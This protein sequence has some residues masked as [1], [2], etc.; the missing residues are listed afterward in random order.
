MSFE[1]LVLGLFSG[2]RPGTSL[3]AVLVLLRAPA[4]RRPLLFFTAAG[5]A[6]SWVVGVVVVG[7]FHGADV[8]IGGGTLTAVLDVAFG[9]A[10]LG[11][12]AGL[13]RGWVQPPARRTDVTPRFA[14]LRDPS[15]RVA[16]A[17]GVATHFPGLIY[18]VALNAIAAEQPGVLGTGLQVALYDVLWFM[19]PIG[20]LVLVIVRPGVALAWLEAATAWARAHEHVVI[21]TALV[22]I[23]AYLVAK[24][25]VNL[26]D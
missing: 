11:F 2:L 19:I 10:A 5:L 1:A 14:R 12:A 6:A 3:A 25:A 21:V 8:A 16:A 9:A 23:G 18:L 4:P 7:V 20:S 13:Q 22:L 26:L 24:G 15:L 17:A